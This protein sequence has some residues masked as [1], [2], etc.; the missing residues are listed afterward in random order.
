MCKVVCTLFYGGLFI[1][2]KGELTL[3]EL[4]RVKIN[5]EEHE[6]EKGIRILDFL[7]RQGIEHPHICYSEVL[8]PIQTCDTC[9]C[10]VDGKIIRACSTVMEEGMNIMTSS[11]R[12]ITAQTEAMDRILENH[13]LYCT[14][15]DNNN[16]NCRVHNTAEL[17]EVEHQTRPFR[18]KG[19]EV[20][21]SYPFYR[22]AW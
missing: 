20:D 12:S 15:C 6:V 17:L 9:M 21:M 3:S 13:L 10:E 1:L 11:E 14:V 5:G 2:E 7:L 4:V 8:G 18:E 19:Y 16:G 22:Y